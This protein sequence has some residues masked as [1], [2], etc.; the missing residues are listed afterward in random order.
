MDWS[1]VLASQG[2]E[3]GIYRSEDGGWLL[4]VSEFSY[5]PALRHITEYQRENRFWGLR[6]R[7]FHQNIY[8]DWRCLI[9]V[10]LTV[11]FYAWSSQ[12]GGQD[13]GCMDNTA[14]AKG[15]WWRLFTAMWLHA[16]LGHLAM[17]LVFGFLFFGLAM[18]RYGAGVGVFAAY[19]AG[20]AGNLLGLVVYGQAHRSLGAS[21]MVMGALGLVTVP[22]LMDLKRG[23]GDGRRFRMNAVLAGLMLFVLLGVNPDSD[24]VAHF[25]GFLAGLTLGILLTLF[26]PTVQ[27]PWLNAASA[28]GFVVLTMWPWWR[29]ANDHP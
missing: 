27:K 16:D 24:V 12:P 1:L 11:F 15:Q 7:V 20:A 25:G 4:A 23:A 8:F 5:K 21:G 6:R 2:I 14:V 17:N 19:V 18:G 9:W 10:F 13:A 22:L 3:H 26:R 29:A 28:I